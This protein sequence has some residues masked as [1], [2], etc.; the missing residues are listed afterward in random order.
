MKLAKK[1]SFTM[2]T[3]GAILC[4]AVKPAKGK[5]LWRGGR[6]DVG[7]RKSGKGRDEA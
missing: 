3:S 2:V 1:V 7:K 6:E 5:L 4:D